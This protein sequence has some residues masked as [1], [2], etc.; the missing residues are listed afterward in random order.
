[1]SQVVRC[2]LV[3][4][5]TGGGPPSCPAL[6]GCF[7][8]SVSNCFS[9]TGAQPL[10]PPMVSSTLGFCSRE[11]LTHCSQAKPVLPTSTCSLVQPHTPGWAPSSPVQTPPLLSPSQVLPPPQRLSLR[12]QWEE[13]LE[14]TPMEAGGS[15]GGGLCLRVLDTLSAIQ[16]SHQHLTYHRDWQ[17]F[18]KGPE[19]DILSLVNQVVSAIAAQLYSGGQKQLR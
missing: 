1:M 12:S 11:R 7:S 5:G 15:R 19:V 8:V 16:C 10:P 17:T 3:G 14:M 6:K 18:C 4:T 13:S 2:L 9:P